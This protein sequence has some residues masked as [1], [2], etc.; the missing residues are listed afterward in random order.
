MRCDRMWW[1]PF[2]GFITL[3]GDKAGSFLLREIACR[4]KWTLFSVHEK[5]LLPFRY[6]LFNVYMCI[7]YLLVHRV[8][9]HVHS[10]L[11]VHRVFIHVLRVY[12]Y[13]EYI[14][15]ERVSSTSCVDTSLAGR[16]L[17]LC[18]CSFTFSLTSVG[19]ASLRCDRTRWRPF[20]RQNVSEGT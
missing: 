5:I 18:L 4:L 1:S 2:C 19:D 9:L 15:S 11:H 6:E 14:Y 16:I 13:I 3:V 17:F 10:Y 7:E 20:R 12:L 8:F